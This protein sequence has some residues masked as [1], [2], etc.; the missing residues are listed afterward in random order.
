MGKT[1]LFSIRSQAYLHHG[2]KTANLHRHLTSALGID[3]EHTLAH[4]VLLLLIHRTVDKGGKVTVEGCDDTIPRFL[5]FGDLIKLLLD[6]GGKIIVEHLREVVDEVIVDH[7]TDIGRFEACLLT[8]VGLACHLVSHLAVLEFQ[9][10]DSAFLTGSIFLD[11]IVT[12]LYGADGWSI[13]RG[14]AYAKFFKFLYKATFVISAGTLCVALYRLHLAILQWL[15]AMQGRK[16]TFLSFALL[17]G[18]GTVNAQET[19]EHKYLAS[20]C[21]DIG[22]A[23]HADGG[24][25]LFKLC[26]GHL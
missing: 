9:D 20:G 17:I 3:A 19:V 15:V 16:Q 14:S 26:L 12:I 24:D 23:T 5:A 10:I 8:T 6:V 25:G 1:R 7:C 21:K 18:T 13:S 22:G 2:T 4:L 11:Y